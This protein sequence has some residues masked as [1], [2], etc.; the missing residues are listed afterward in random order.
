MQTALRKLLSKNFNYFTISYDVRIKNMD[1]EVDESL[2]HDTLAKLLVYGDCPDIKC[3]VET[4]VHF[5]SNNSFESWYK[6]FTDYFGKYICFILEQVKLN[7][8]KEPVFQAYY[9]PHYD[10]ANYRVILEE[11]YDKLIDDLRKW[12]KEDLNADIAAFSIQD[13]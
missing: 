11:D 10:K 8:K 7:E 3:F 4:T 13:L 6:I 1:T 12:S 5:T 9:N 2:I